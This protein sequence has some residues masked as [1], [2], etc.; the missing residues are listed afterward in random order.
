MAHDAPARAVPQDAQKRPAATVPHE[1]HR[2]AFGGSIEPGAA[3]DGSDGDDMVDKA[4][5]A[6][7]TLAAA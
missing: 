7:G 2:D 4:I 3:G 5:R 1:G 6:R